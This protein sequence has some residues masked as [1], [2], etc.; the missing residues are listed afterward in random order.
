MNYHLIGIEG[1]AMSGLAKILEAHGHRVLGTD[2]RTTGHGAEK[3]ADDTERVVYTPAVRERS[4]AWPELESARSRGLETLRA[5][6][7]L[8]ELT[9]NA[10]LLAVTGAH[11]K[12][13]TTAM[14]AYILERAGTN[15]TV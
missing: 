15:P 13:S 4:P 5:D 6:E 8:G 2:L 10:T 9:K 11:G 3:I 14:L 1:S 7:L 12:S